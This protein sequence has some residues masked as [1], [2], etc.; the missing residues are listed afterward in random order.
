MHGQGGRRPRLPRHLG[1]QSA[2]PGWDAAMNVVS[3]APTR[4][5][6]DGSESG[7]NL[8]VRP[9]LA[10]LSCSR[11]EAAQGKQVAARVKHRSASPAAGRSPE[12]AS[13]SRSAEAG[14]G[15]SRE[16]RGLRRECR[17][18]ARNQDGIHPFVLIS[19]GCPGLV[20]GPCSQRAAALQPACP[21]P[22]APAGG[23]DQSAEAGLIGMRTVNV[24][25]PGS[26]STVIW[27]PW[28]STI[29]FTIARPR[30]VPPV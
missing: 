27:P 9:D 18:T 10:R 24:V 17:R 23:R 2:E 5:Q 21:R 19:G 11:A 30:P 8:S 3:P 13:G 26:L 28:P 7:R 22:R 6:E 4:M 15:C 25:A 20:P 12:T 1:C 29:A 16:R 14:M